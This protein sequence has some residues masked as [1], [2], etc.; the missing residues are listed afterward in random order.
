MSLTNRY[1]TFRGMGSKDQQM[2]SATHCS[3]L[4]SRHCRYL[5][6]GTQIS[7]IQVTINSTRL[8]RFGAETAQGSPNHFV[9]RPG[10]GTS[11]RGTSESWGKHVLSVVDRSV[12]KDLDDLDRTLSSD[13]VD[14]SRHS[15]KRAD[16]PAWS[17]TGH[18]ESTD[19][20]DL[21]DGPAETGGY[22]RT[23]GDLDMSLTSS[24]LV[25]LEELAGGFWRADRGNCVS[26]GR[27]RHG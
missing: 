22:M 6:L 12:T 1:A 5:G 13:S 24:D 18:L 27:C 20:V 23:F 11:S 17:S 9:L 19:V 8:V 21:D 15:C 4:T 26:T 25:F 10:D 14:V 3:T 7:A 2:E 16:L